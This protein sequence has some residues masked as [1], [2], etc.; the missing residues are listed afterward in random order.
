MGGY[1]K[2]G[3]SSAGVVFNDHTDKFNVFGVYN[4]SYINT[5]HNFT[6][7][8]I[9][10]FN[11]IMSDYN[12]N[13]ISTQNSYNNNYSLGTDYFISANHTIGFLIS[14]YSRIDNF[15]KNNS[16]QIANRSVLDSTIISS[17][18]LNRHYSNIN[19]N[20]NYKGKLDKAGTT[21]SADFNYI[22]YNRNSSEYITN[23]FFTATGSTY[24]APLLFQNLSPSNIKNWLTKI[25]FSSPLSKTSKLEAGLKYSDVVSNNTLVFGPQVK[26]VYTSDPNFSNNFLYDEDVNAAYINYQ[27]K[28]D[29]FDLT[30][31]LRAEQTVAKGNSVTAAN[32][33]NSNYVDLFPQVFLAYKYD[34][35][36]DFSISFN[37]GIKRPAYED[38]N[39]FLYYS[40]LY[41]YRAGN[42]NLKPQYTNL[43][44]LTYN[45]KKA[46][47][48]TLYNSIVTNAYEFP[49][50]QQNDATKVNVTTRENLGRIYNYGIKFNA[51]LVFT[52]WWNANFNLDASY[53]RYVAYPV[54]G[55]LDKGT[56]YVAFSTTQSFIISKTLTA[57]VKGKYESP[58]FYGINQFKANYTADAGISQQLFN[59]RGSL[60]LSVS[61]IFNTVRDRSS[62]NYQNLNLTIVDK[63]E[64]QV[65]RLT[66]T[67]RLG[68]SAIKSAATHTTG[69]EDEQKRAGG[70]G[71]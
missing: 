4:Y 14:G 47:L 36:N 44:E 67:Y 60:K 65:A 10:N 70:T 13:Y 31:G 1:G 41:D 54:N 43:I 33:V 45:Y 52:S 8:R 9:I 27:G 59:T 28:F 34:D 66:F 35:K 2:Y 19:Y 32:I 58:A 24:R 40:D 37:R 30:A 25:D 12:G 20:F 49:F 64:S 29:K 46:Y 51:A 62:T 22:N 42:P 11:N 26:G 71:K 23:T 38:L 3:K 50:Y 5:F 17:S 69:T 57:E 68:R 55:N 63:R 18:D 7:D 61:D 39:P 21:L 16:L 15:V 6:S 53:Q 56:Q 48:F